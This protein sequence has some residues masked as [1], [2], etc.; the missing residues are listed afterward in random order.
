[1]KHPFGV[2]LFVVTTLSF[3][4]FNALAQSASREDLL[5]QIEAKRAELQ[6]LEKRFLAPSEEDRAAYAEF[7]RQPDT[8]LIRLLPREVYESETYQS[9]K[10]TVTVRGGGSYYSFTRHTHEYGNCTD[11]GLERDHLLV[12][13]AGAD[14]GMAIKLGDVPLEEITLE[15]PSARFMSS[16]NAPSREPEAR[17]EQR[18][19]ASGTTI[20][21]LTY[22]NNLPVELKATYLLRSINYSEADVLVAL[23]VVSK[24]ADGSITIAWKL[25]KKY[26]KPE[27]ART[28]ESAI[29]D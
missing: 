2:V 3:F 23:R 8:G 10:K 18:R 6:S 20:D 24:D 11:I 1:M 26:A 7:L 29:G 19:F 15:H 5:Q 22:K 13:F 21:G 14:F 25:L 4:S 16:Y 12:G 27:L 9:N 17:A 28:T